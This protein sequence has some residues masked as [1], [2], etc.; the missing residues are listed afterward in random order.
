MSLPEHQRFGPKNH[1][2]SVA[3]G[4]R[5]AAPSSPPPPPCGK[6]EWIC[7]IQ[8][9]C[10]RKATYLS[11]GYCFHF[12]VSGNNSVLN[13]LYE[14]EITLF[15]SEVNRLSIKVTEYARFQ[16]NYFSNYNTVS[17]GVRIL[18]RFCLSCNLHA[19]V[20]Q[21][22]QATLMHSSRT[23]TPPPPPL[24]KLSTTIT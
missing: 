7:G 12:Q 18:K 6:V 23:S 1:I 3:G 15:L 24:A 17:F 13:G 22:L 14:K 9:F 21:F 11:Y 4:G 5:A 2:I 19:F 16:N 10:F 20:S 8:V